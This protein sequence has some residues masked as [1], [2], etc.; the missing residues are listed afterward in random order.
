MSSAKR[1]RGRPRRAGAD[2]EILTV[3]RAL[4]DER[5]YQ[6]FSVDEVAERAGVAKTTVY[7]RWASKGA[8]AAA[9]ITPAPLP[10]SADE[11]L[12]E[13]RALLAT[14]ADAEDDAEI[15]GVMRAILVP[16]RA[17][18][19]RLVENADQLLGAV[20]IETFI[21]DSSG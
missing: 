3:A 1:G 2:E 10:S 12:R 18:L 11:L 19:G 7:R 16:R 13:T 17:L 6:A 8:L 15:L 5:G 20:W 21:R 4:L 9:A 14:F